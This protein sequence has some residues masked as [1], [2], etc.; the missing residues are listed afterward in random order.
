MYGYNKG[1]FILSNN[2]VYTDRICC[3]EKYFYE[4]IT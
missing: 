1:L 3:N 2:N 4:S